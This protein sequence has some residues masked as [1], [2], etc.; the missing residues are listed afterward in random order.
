MAEEGP[1][2]VL[3]EGGSCCMSGGV[4]SIPR[5]KDGM[6][7]SSGND[8]GVGGRISDLGQGC[9]V[10]GGMVGRGDGCGMGEGMV[11]IRDG[12]GVDEGMVRLGDGCGV[13]TEGSRVR[14]TRGVATGRRGGDP[15]GTVFVLGPSVVLG[16]AGVAASSFGSSG[17]GG[18]TQSRRCTAVSTSVMSLWSSVPTG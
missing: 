9:G 11:G 16:P 17:I 2:D 10:G 4:G 1:I 15:V 8:Y 6:G 12:C 7:D 3:W 14:T 13:D 18:C 5:S